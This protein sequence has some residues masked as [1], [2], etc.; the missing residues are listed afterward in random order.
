MG[1]IGGSPENNKMCGLPLKGFSVYRAPHSLVGF[2]LHVEIID[3]PTPLVLEL[4]KEGLW[5]AISML[6][7]DWEGETGHGGMPPPPKKHHALGCPF[8]KSY[9]QF[10][11]NII[12]QLYQGPLPTLKASTTCLYS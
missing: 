10:L 12:H 11:H 4:A 3:P 9:I 5:S 7:I 8:T 6:L 1:T 2:S